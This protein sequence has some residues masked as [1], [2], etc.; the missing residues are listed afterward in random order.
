MAT[1][2][3][4]NW[5]FVYYPPAVIH[6]VYKIEP[7]KLYIKR[8]ELCAYLGDPIVR[9]PSLRTRRKLWL[10][11]DKEMTST[12]RG[13]EPAGEEWGR[14]TWGVDSWSRTT[15]G[16]R[17]CWW[18]GG[19]GPDRPGTKR[20]KHRQTAAVS[21]HIQAQLRHCALGTGSACLLPEWWPDSAD[22]EAGTGSTFGCR[23]SCAVPGSH[24]KTLIILLY[25]K[26][27]YIQKIDFL[28]LWGVKSNHKEDKWKPKPQQYWLIGLGDR[29]WVII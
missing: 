14:P 4:L 21:H 22:T 15:T 3:S 6:H 13:A 19:A 27:T 26:K 7:Y 17:W 23:R 2:R 12:P 24:K 28:L 29:E 9:K 18:E 11:Q 8:H 10:V 16:Y 20:G 1:L 5:L 25:F